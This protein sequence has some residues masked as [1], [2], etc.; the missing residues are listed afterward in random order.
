MSSLGF[1]HHHNLTYNC[2]APLGGVTRGDQASHV[3]PR[4]W[5]SA[6]LPVASCLLSVQMHTIPKSHPAS[7]SSQ[8][9]LPPACLPL[10]PASTSSF[11]N[12][13]SPHPLHILTLPPT[14]QLLPQLLQ[15][16]STLLAK[17][18]GCQVLLTCPGIFAM[19]ALLSHLPRP[20]D[21]PLLFFSHFWYHSP[22]SCSDF[23]PSFP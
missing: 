20:L 3:Y 19:W 10:Q 14:I 5:V 6:D 1:S 2:D 23:S 12:S 17:P 4:S 16:V 15:A 21:T 8:P 18:R 22:I 9:L 11:P 13:L 7:P